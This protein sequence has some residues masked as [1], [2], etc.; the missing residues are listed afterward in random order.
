MQFNP[1]SIR[2]FIG[3]KDYDISRNFY[4]DLGFEEVII[5]SN[6]SLFEIGNFGFYLQDAYVKDW[7]DNSML[8]L[9]VENTEKLLTHIKQL[10]LDNKYPG[11]RLSEVVYND[12]GKEFFL[13]DPSGVL[14]HIGE[15]R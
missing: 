10:A 6:M 13:H 14:W 5:S 9:E 11:V 7:I 3:S 15:F 4:S 1:K 2:A 12:W 8:F